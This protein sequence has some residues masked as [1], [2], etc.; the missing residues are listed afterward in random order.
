MLFDLNYFKYCFLKPT[1]LDFNEVYLEA[2]FRR[3]AKDLTTEPSESFLY[4]DFQ[5]RNV[6]LDKDGNPYF[7]DFQGGRKVP[8]I[9][10][11]PPSFGRLLPNILSSCAAS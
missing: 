8:S 9:T 3:M 6:M 11:W 7:I 1:E 2:N 10:T 5:A 4:R